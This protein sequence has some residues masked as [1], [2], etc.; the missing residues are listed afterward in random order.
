MSALIALVA[1]IIIGSAALAVL[2]AL[3]PKSAGEVHDD[4]LEAAHDDANRA[5]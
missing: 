1:F 3:T 5:W 2:A 4:G